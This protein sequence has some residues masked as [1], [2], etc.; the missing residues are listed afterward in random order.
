MSGLGQYRYSNNPMLD[1]KQI[2]EIILNYSEFSATFQRKMHFK[3]WNRTTYIQPFNLKF[4]KNYEKAL[5]LKSKLIHFV[6][7]DGKKKR[8]D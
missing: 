6:Y 7:I 4:K 8:Q 5:Y 2:Q 3:N 1:P